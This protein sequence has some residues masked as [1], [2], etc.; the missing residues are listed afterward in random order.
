MTPGHHVVTGVAGGAAGKAGLEA[1]CM[2]LMSDDRARRRRIQQGTFGQ[3]LS[4]TSVG[5][6]SPQEK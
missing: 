4:A 1:L 2:V 3:Q 6:V 5:S